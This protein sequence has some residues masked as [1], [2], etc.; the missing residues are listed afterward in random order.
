MVPLL[1]KRH[2]LATTQEYNLNSVYD[3]YMLTVTITI[4]KDSTQKEGET[5]D[6]NSKDSDYGLHNQTHFSDKLLDPCLTCITVYNC[7][8]TQYSKGSVDYHLVRPAYRTWSIRNYDRNISHRMCREVHIE[9][10]LPMCALWRCHPSMRYPWWYH[11]LYKNDVWTG[12]LHDFSK[13]S[14]VNIL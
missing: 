3:I 13:Y 7:Y 10:K 11:L 12:K 8:I 2:L 5:I 4:W 14:L 1:K 6:N 9:P